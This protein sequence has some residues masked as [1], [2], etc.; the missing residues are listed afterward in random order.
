MRTKSF[1]KPDGTTITVEYD[2]IGGYPNVIT[3]SQWTDEDGNDRHAIV[4]YLQ[5]DGTRYE[6]YKRFKPWDTSDAK[7]EYNAQVRA[8]QECTR[9]NTEETSVQFVIQELSV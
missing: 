9:T 7:A 8:A 3:R 4:S 6:A 5:P 2:V 1:A